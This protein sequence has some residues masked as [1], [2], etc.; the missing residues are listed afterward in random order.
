[1][2]LRVGAEGRGDWTRGL[3]SGSDSGG[4]DECTACGGDDTET[5]VTHHLHSKQGSSRGSRRVVRQIWL[6]GR[7]SGQARKGGSKYASEEELKV[8]VDRAHTH[9]GRSAASNCAIPSETDADGPSRV[10]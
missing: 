6:L 8:I 3:L 2:D 1:M 9:P 5:S 10:P 4:S 7:E